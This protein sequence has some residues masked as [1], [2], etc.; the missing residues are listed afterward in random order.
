[1]AADHLQV[2]ALVAAAEVVLLAG[3]A[4]REHGRMPRQ[5]SSTC[6]QSRTLPPSP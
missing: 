2:G 4:A 3:H 6:S 5:W 1:M